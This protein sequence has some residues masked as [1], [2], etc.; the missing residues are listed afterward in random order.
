MSKLI[1]RTWFLAA[2]VLLAACSSTPSAPPGVGIWDVSIN[3]PVGEQGGTWTLAADGTG[4]M[5]SDQGNQNIE[6]IMFDGNDIS[7][8]VDI[9]AGGQAL[10]LEFSGSVDGDS[11]SGDFSSDFGDFGV[12]GTRQ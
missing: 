3:T 6:G 7:F 11:L 9:D 12:S 5:G 10:S 8:A 2:L 1:K 4:I